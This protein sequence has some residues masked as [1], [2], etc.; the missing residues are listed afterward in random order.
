[1]NP[2]KFLTE[3]A[4][5][6]GAGW[7]AQWYKCRSCSAIRLCHQS[8]T[9]NQHCFLNSRQVYIEKWPDFDDLKKQIIIKEVE[10]TW[11]SSLEKKHWMKTLE[12]FMV[13]LK[14]Q[15]TNLRGISF[16]TPTSWQHTAFFPWGGTSWSPWR[17]S[18]DCSIVPRRFYCHSFWG[19][20]ENDPHIFKEQV[21]PKSTMKPK[22]I[23][24]SQYAC[25]L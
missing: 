23:N 11:V 14:D 5:S 8:V 7:G 21:F 17:W 24:I 19:S 1:M 3:S 25:F 6:L 16:P 9:R 15:I 13:K 12:S 2:Q 22:S 18:G 10:K 20:S 4:V